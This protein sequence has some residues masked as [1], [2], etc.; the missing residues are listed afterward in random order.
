MYAFGIFCLSISF[1]CI[2]KG[3]ARKVIGRVIGAA[4]FILSGWFLYSMVSTGVFISESYSEPSII[5]AIFFFINFGL[6][7]IW[8]ALFVKFPVSGESDEE[9]SPNK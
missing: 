6:P 5:N 7:G 9:K 1:T 8:Y 4:V 2:V 3:A